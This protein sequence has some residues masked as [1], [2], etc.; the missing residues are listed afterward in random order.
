MAQ[1]NNAKPVPKP[2]LEECLKTCFNLSYTWP[3]EWHTL[4]L[5]L[6]A[7][8]MGEI[9]VRGKIHIGF[10]LTHQFVDVPPHVV[11]VNL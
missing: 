6:Q 1:S 7:L 8:K 9:V 11:E 10:E 4:P 5:I 3:L 2:G